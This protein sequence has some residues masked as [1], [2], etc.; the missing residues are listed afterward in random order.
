MSAGRPPV[1]GVALVLTAVIWMT[2]LAAAISWLH[3]PPALAVV[4]AALAVTLLASA[5][6]TTTRRTR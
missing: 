4:L 1:A 2:V 6:I 3:G 5:A